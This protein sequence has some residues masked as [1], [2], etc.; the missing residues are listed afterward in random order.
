M[1]VCLYVR[2]WVLECV[3]VCVDSDIQHVTHSD[4]I[5]KKHQLYYMKI[6]YTAN[7][8]IGRGHITVDI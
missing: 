5:V 1:G 7:H 2:V 4:R 8:N 6:P 3:R